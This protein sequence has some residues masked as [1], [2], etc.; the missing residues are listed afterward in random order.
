MDLRH[1]DCLGETG[2]CTLADKSVDMI[3]CDMPYNVTDMKWDK[4]LDLNAVFKEYNRIIKDNGAIVLFGKMPFA[5]DLVSANRRFFRYELIWDKMRSCNFYHANVKP[6]PSHENIYVFYKKKPT[7]NPQMREGGAYKRDNTKSKAGGHQPRENF[8]F[9]EGAREYTG[10]F[11]VTILP[12][13]QD[14]GLHPTQK[15]VALIE[16]LV[17]TYTNEGDI[18]LDNTFGS[19]SCAVACQ[20]LGRRFVGWEMNEAYFKVAS[21]RLEKNTLL[22]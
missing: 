10:R 4:A 2:M 22:I 11:P 1:G 20:N 3:C 9:F 14:R 17:K 7:Y 15:P 8:K 19:G 12:F 16:W 13:K 21:E 5:L 6:L 18:V